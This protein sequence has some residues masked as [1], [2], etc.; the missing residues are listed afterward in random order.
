M[1]HQNRGRLA[2]VIGGSLLASAFLINIAFFGFLA[3]RE[4]RQRQGCVR[5]G[6]AA[7]MSGDHC[8]TPGKAVRTDGLLL[9]VSG[10][11]RVPVAGAGGEV[12]ADV[13]MANAGEQPRPFDQFGWRLAAPSG[14]DLPY[15]MAN[16]SVG[17]GVLAQRQRSSGAV[18]F[19][20]GHD[21][22]RYAV[23]WRHGF[24][25]QDRQVWVIQLPSQ[26]G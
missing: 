26:S 3:V 23:T 9:S 20:G 16:A 22:G 4:H 8:M 5:L 21:G 19:E 1:E 6:Y 14:A 25:R 11:R 12:C 10:L 24:R 18:C 13:V 2:A 17:A 7:M 15:N